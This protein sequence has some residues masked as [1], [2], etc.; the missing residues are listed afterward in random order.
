MRR[1]LVELRVYYSS[2][3]SVDVCIHCG[4]AQDL[5]TGKTDIY[6]TCAT[7]LHEHPKLYKQKR[8]CYELLVE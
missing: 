5:A 3:A 7:C 2:E 1:Y 4:T 6:R 8:S